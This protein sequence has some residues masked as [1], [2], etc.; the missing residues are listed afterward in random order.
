VSSYQVGLVQI[1]FLD[2]I[3][4]VSSRSK[5]GTDL[6]GVARV[7]V[8]ST[9]DQLKAEVEV[10]DFGDNDIEI[11][12]T[13]FLS[14][15]PP[16]YDHL[17]RNGALTVQRLTDGRWVALLRALR[18]GTKEYPTLNAVSIEEMNELLGADVEEWLE[19]LGFEVGTWKGLNPK[20]GRH[21]EAVAVAIPEAQA[22]LLVLPW[23]LTRV[24]ALM[25]RLGK[26]SLGTN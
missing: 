8:I 13:E 10:R 12:L 9:S 7:A 17:N 4:E 16:I 1:Q 14:T 23:V 11:R 22:H 21:F 19:S 18:P 20:A 15:P 24:I 25:N 6:Q 26:T 3:R 2:E 5:A